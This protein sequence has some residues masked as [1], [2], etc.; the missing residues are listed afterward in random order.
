MR[1]GGAPGRYQTAAE[2]DTFV[3]SSVRVPDL[4]SIT[5]L[6]TSDHVLQIC[7]F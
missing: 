2:L 6:V 3:A 4:S 5:T 1:S 7:Q